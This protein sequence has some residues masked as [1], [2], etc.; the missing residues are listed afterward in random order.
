MAA[1]FSNAATR[2]HS[3]HFHAFTLVVAVMGILVV[4]FVTG[5]GQWL[6]GG[7]SPFSDSLIREGRA[8]RDSVARLIAASSD[9]EVHVFSTTKN[10]QDDPPEVK[11]RFVSDVSSFWSQL[12]RY[13]EAKSW[14][15]ILI[16]PEFD[17]WL[18]KLT[19][20]VEEWHGMLLTPDST[21]VAL[22]SDK[23]Q[24]CL[25]LASAGLPTPETHVAKLCS[26]VAKPRHGCGTDGVVL[27]PEGPRPSNSA[28]PREN[29][30]VEPKVDGIAASVAVVGH[31]IHTTLFPPFAQHFSDT[32]PWTYLGG[33]LLEDP[34]WIARAQKLA[35]GVIQ[36]FPGTLGYFGIDLLLGSTESEDVIL[37]VNPRI[38][39]SWVG[40]AASVGSQ[41]AEA[42]LSPH[43]VTSTTVVPGTTPISFWA[44]GRT[45]EASVLPE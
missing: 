29:W 7:E 40:L 35:R 25:R 20:Q 4:E 26:W 6:I 12:R 32:M 21:F 3:F 45:I 11:K 36:S 42:M 15:I 16:A 38:T 34:N 27:V 30:H 33:S 8:M 10:Q 28:F 9:D 17:D 5:G 19:R 2:R 1:I 14:A 41:L 31:G 39:T 18:L 37:E 44:D 23:T 13:A 43:A 24:T 22:C